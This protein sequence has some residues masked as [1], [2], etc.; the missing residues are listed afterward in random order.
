MGE[1]NSVIWPLKT[2]PMRLEPEAANQTPPAL[3]MATQVGLPLPVGMGYSVKTPAGVIMPI[4][5]ASNSANQMLP[6]QSMAI[7]LGRRP[8]W[9]CRTR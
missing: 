9:V 8:P 6:E 5:L 3:S 4:L 2:R 1:P 7:P